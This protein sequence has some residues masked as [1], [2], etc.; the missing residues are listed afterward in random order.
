MSMGKVVMGPSLLSGIPGEL[1]GGVPVAGGTDAAAVAAGTVPPGSLS[2]GGRRCLLALGSPVA[3][4]AV[5]VA[6]A[7]T[8][9]CTASVGIA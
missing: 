3:A 1:R 9:S 5:A 6:V 2:F 7:K 8:L 4:A